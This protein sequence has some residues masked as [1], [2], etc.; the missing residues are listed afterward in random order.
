MIAH[1]LWF[2][3]NQVMWNFVN[4]VS[5]G[6]QDCIVNVSHRWKITGA[7]KTAERKLA[8]GSLKHG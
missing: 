3:K 4:E 8:D 2:Q 6:G 1:S 7:I 5:I